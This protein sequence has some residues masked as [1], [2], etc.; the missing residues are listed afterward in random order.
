MAVINSTNFNIIF[1]GDE[2][3]NPDI[4][5]FEVSKEKQYSWHHRQIRISLSQRRDQSLHIATAGI[6]KCIPSSNLTVM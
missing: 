5:Y 1:F 2:S 3:H 4:P 6:W